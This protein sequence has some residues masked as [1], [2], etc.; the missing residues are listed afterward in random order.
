MI[1]IK[2]FLDCT[3]WTQ[4]LR[5]GSFVLS[6]KQDMNTTLWIVQVIL[7]AMMF[8][9]G[10]MKTFQPVQKLNKFGWTTRSSEGFVRFVGISELLIGT[11]LILPQ[12]TG[13]LPILTPLAALSLCMIMV[14]A[15]ADHVKNNEIN[16]IG[17]NVIIIS[18]A[19]FVVVGRFGLV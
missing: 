9:L 13:V 1:K 10:V 12:L 16:E 15:I 8:L 2:G 18:L 3:Y 11:A 19:A 4:A 6:M 7:G 17:K 14:L 5:A